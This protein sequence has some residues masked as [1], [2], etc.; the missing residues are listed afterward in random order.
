MSIS[1]WLKQFSFFLRMTE[2]YCVLC[3]NFPS[4]ALSRPP[5]FPI[6]CVSTST[7][8]MTSLVNISRYLR[9]SPLPTAHREVGG[10]ADSLRWASMFEVSR[11]LGQRRLQ[12]WLEGEIR[13][14]AAIAKMAPATRATSV[15]A[16]N[17]TAKLKDSVPQQTNT[18]LIMRLD[19]REKFL[20][21][22]SN[23]LAHQGYPKTFQSK[24]SMVSLLVSDNMKWLMICTSR[25]M[26]L[27]LHFIPDV[28]SKPT[29][30]DDVGD[31]AALK[32][33]TNYISLTGY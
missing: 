29:V 22:I 1:E 28:S 6:Q 33:A 32:H 25:N 15:H 21:Q 5:G 16:G 27:L 31:T 7:E 10:Q 9:R 13:L 17:P 8:R 12:S 30:R 24:L 19:G 18:N 4:V 14:T 2:M 23:T 20:E 3:D 11:Y 26:S